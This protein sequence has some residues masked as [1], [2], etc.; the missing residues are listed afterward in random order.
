MTY[1][2]FAGYTMKPGFTIVQNGGK[3]WHLLKIENNKEFHWFRVAENKDG[4][5][6]GTAPNE[7]VITD[8]P[9]KDE[10]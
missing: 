7:T 6:T 2:K 3:L 10:G 5:F 1:K 8:R 4:S 9:L